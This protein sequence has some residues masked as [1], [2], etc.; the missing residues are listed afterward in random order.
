MPLVVFSVVGFILPGITTPSEAA[1]FGVLSVLILAAC[2]GRLSWSM[3]TKSVEGTLRVTVMVFFIILASKTF[4]QILAFSGATS[5]LIKWATIYDF[6]SLTMLLVMF[7][8]LLVLG[9]FVDA[10]SMMMLTIPIFF[11]IA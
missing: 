3:L 6:G 10:I 1:A 7:A 5:G 2:Y 4:S 11:P 9:M 8:L